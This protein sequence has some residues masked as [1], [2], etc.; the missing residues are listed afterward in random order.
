MVAAR[1]VLDRILPALKPQSPPLVL[2]LAEDATMADIAR[3]VMEAGAS[4]N[5]SPESMSAILSALGSLAKVLETAE[6]EARI[7]ALE[8]KHNGKKS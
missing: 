4:G 5:T 2:N 1:I 7:T 6:L 3:A 8:E